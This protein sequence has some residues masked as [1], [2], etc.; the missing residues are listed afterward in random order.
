MASLNVPHLPAFRK[1]PISKSGVLTL[2]GFGVRIRMQ[3]GH[4]EIEDGIGPD[5]RKL[6][7]G[8]VGHGLRRLVMIGSD[9]FITLEAMRWISD[10]GASFVMLDRR[11]KVITVTGPVASSDAKLRRAQALA[12]G[13]GIALKISK[14]L[15]SQKLAGQELVVR[16]ILH[17][18]GTAATIARFRVDLPSAESIESVRLIESQAA[19]AYW[20]AWSDVPIR[21]PR[22][23]ERR[24]PEHWKRFGSRISP[25]T[26]SPRL[27][28]SPPNAVLNLLYSV[29]ESESTLAASAMGLLPE[30]GLLHTDTPN[31]NSLSC[32]LMEVCRP[33]CDAFVLH[34]LQS[35]PFRRTDF[36]EDRNGNCRI[37]SSLAI[38]LCETSETWRKFVAPVAE[39]VAQSL[40][41]SA[42]KRG[43]TSKLARHWIAT[44]LTQR[45][46]R[47]IKGSDV[48]G[49]DTPKPEHVCSG[50][51]KTIRAERNHC[52]DCAIG[53]ATERLIGV[54]RLGRVAA[55]SPE[56]RAKHAASRRRHAQACSKWDAS[57]QPA[58]LTSEVFSQ[59]VQP[60]LSNIAT[61]VI[62]SSIFVSRWYA[63]RIRQG[64][65]PHP[66]HWRALAKLVG[67][68]S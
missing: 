36:W 21:W 24:I 50:C 45:T 26:H 65:V 59:Q 20:Q 31:R 38:K 7:L 40:A 47:E 42:S 64:Y 56:A 10:V 4:L 6:R 55:R 16:E 5:R 12:L 46:K 8:R 60:L 48:P 54:A 51:G 68:S 37:A 32:D 57:T 15:I 49:V 39:H 19:R 9:G 67:V 35:E 18:A 13:N 41:S 66:R 11:G 43:P 2:Y 23:D 44:R 33:K 17:D 53:D 14:E 62:R 30:I 58:W 34:W 28:A 63:G 22:K 25:L 61:S 52:A 27:A 29:L 1:S 3:A